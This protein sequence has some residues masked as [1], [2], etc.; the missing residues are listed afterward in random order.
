MRYA[1]FIYKMSSY[2]FGYTM[3]EGQSYDSLKK[4]FP[5]PKFF[6]NITEPVGL[7]LIQGPSIVTEAH[8]DRYE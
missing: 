2:N 6:E 4:D 8:Y 1:D 3:K 7:D 5:N